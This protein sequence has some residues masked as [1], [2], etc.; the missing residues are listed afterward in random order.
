MLTDLS[1][2]INCEFLS[3]VIISLDIYRVNDMYRAEGRIETSVR[4]QCSRCLEDF[5]HPLHAD[6]ALNFTSQPDT[7]PES[8]I[9]G[10]YEIKAE[11][12]GLVIFR[13]DEIDLTESI[14]DQILMALPIQPLCREDCRGLCPQCGTN[15][16]L[17][18]CNCEKAVFNPK[19]QNLAGLEINK[20]KNR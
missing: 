16:N 10:E 19:F 3:P 11:Q 8:L 12:A 17:G 14:Q 1:E 4:F 7:D 9:Q 15:L 5:I 20:K 18:G 6:F 13:D 2:S